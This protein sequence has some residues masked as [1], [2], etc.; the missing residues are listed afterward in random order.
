MATMSDKAPVLSVVCPFYNE[1]EI[2]DKALARMLANLSALEVTW[3]LIVVN[4]GSTDRSLALAEAAASRA[5]NVTVVSY[6]VNRGRGH[7]LLAGI[8]RARGELIA[9]TEIDCSWGD[10]IVSRLLEAIQL[11]PAADLVIASP[12]LPSGGYRNVPLHRVLLSAIGNL[13]LRSFFT[14]TITMN[15]GMTRMYRRRVFDMVNPVEKGK[16]FHLEVLNKAIAFGF[17]PI[18]IPAV[19]TWPDRD[20]TTT[21]GGRPRRSSSR[22]GALIRSHLVF[23]A[24]VNPTRYFWFTAVLL[25]ATAAVVLALALRSL[26]VGPMAWNVLVV[27]LLLS[28]LGLVFF[29]AGVLAA[30]H[31][32]IERELWR[33]EAVIRDLRRPQPPGDE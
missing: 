33:L 11:D 4:D 30:Q 2:L 6:A 9:T 3:E 20:L 27:G 17:R 16:E 10:D 14:Y 15:T 32:F 23:T 12:H 8:R 29:A 1:E 7:A 13:I 19:L 24:F 21:G 18:E 5:S 31:R 26:V 22:V 28:V 25:L